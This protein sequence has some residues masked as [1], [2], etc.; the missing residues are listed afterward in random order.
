MESNTYN[1]AL[2]EDKWYNFWLEKKY[3]HADEKRVLKGE[4][5]KFSVVLPPP[6]VTGV[7]HVGHAL[8]STLQDI[9]CRWKRMKGFEVCWIPGTDHAGIATQWVVERELAK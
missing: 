2:F 5:P 1:P 6:N 4:K 7:L 3:F 8:N 9:V